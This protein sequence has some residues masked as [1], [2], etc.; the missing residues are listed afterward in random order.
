[1]IKLYRKVV[2]QDSKIKPNLKLN[3]NYSFTVFKPTILNTGLDNSEGIKSLLWFLITMGKLRI[4]YILDHRKVIHY[5]FIIP[6]N[7][8]FP[9]MNKEDLQIGPCGTDPTYR[10]QG[11][12]TK[13]LE[14]IPVLFSEQTNTF[15][16][17][18]TE[19]NVISQHVIEKAGYDFQCLVR[20]SGILKVLKT[21]N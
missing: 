19:K 3:N 11:L 10:G 20:C 12:Y 13:A 6:K 5:S 1:M 4:F 9:F 21:I 2:N 7:F 14:M 15:W 17:Y 16:I 8:R 18:T